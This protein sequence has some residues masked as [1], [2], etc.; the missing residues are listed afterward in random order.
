MFKYLLILVSIT[1][2]FTIINASSGIKFGL[3]LSPLDY[4]SRNYITGYEATT[5]GMRTDNAKEFYTFMKNKGYSFLILDIIADDGRP[6]IKSNILKS[7]NYMAEWEYFY[8]AT[9][10]A[11]ESGFEVYGCPG[12]LSYKASADLEHDQIPG[13]VMKPDKL[14]V[15]LYETL[16]GGHLLGY[17]MSTM[18]E[19]H[20]KEILKMMNREKSILLTSSPYLEA[21]G[22][23]TEDYASYP[24]KLEDSIRGYPYTDMLEGNVISAYA[25]GRDKDVWVKTAAYERTGYGFT[26]DE[27]PNVWIFRRVAQRAN[28]FII[29]PS[30]VS[31]EKE[32]KELLRFKTEDVKPIL[33]KLALEKDNRPVANVIDLTSAQNR[34]EATYALQFAVSALDA[35]GYRAILT[36]EPIEGARLYYLLLPAIRDN[37]QTDLPNWVKGVVESNAKVVINPLG[38]LGSSSSWSLINDLLGKQSGFNNAVTKWIYPALGKSWVYDKGSLN[39]S[40]TGWQSVLTDGGVTLIAKKDK[41]ILVNTPIPHIKMQHYL[42]K[43]LDKQVFDKE[44]ELII[45]YGQHTAILN[46][47][48]ESRFTIT[49]PEGF[50]TVEIIHRDRAGKIKTDTK[51]YERNLSLSLGRHEVLVLLCK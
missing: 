6:L 44:N 16:V 32:W 26:T 12:I 23:I 37:I 24:R 27:L 47:G 43:A 48:E 34:V 11:K 46:S 50:K 21:E 38:L 13:W 9:S 18:P 10:L 4:V 30:W 19:D 15:L 25:R 45:S 1:L 36:H 14:T 2:T 20:Y 42:A 28:N 49:L 29:K 41:Y 7:L 3:H 51:A 35:C 40:L 33:E 22:Y 5:E 39:L 31:A 8:P 17:Y